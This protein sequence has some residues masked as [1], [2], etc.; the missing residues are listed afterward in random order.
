[1]AWIAAPLVGAFIG[2][3]TNV[4]AIRLL[5][6]PHQ[7]VR[8]WRFTLQ[9]LI[10]RRRREIAASV[11]DVIDREL[12]PWPDLVERLYTPAMEQS[13]GRAVAKVACHRLQ[14]RLPA[15]LPGGIREVAG[16]ALEEGL[17]REMPAALA[18]LKC[19]LKA[20]E[21]ARFS[22][23]ETVAQ[24][25]DALDLS[26]VEGIVLAVASRELR[27][28]EILGGLLGFL[29]GLVQAALLSI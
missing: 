25:I 3:V 10:P 23:G 21:V 6:R 12:L 20:G 13:L 11:A 29:I 9:G 22:L 18:E 27:Y 1:M 15:F 4:L 2:W 28:I 24:R 17:R 19:M 26:Q 5:F 14:E 7:P 8:I 16:R